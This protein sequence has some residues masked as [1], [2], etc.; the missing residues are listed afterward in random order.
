MTNIFSEGLKPPI[1]N[2]LCKKI[3][4]SAGLS[5]AICAVAHGLGAHGAG[6]D[7]NLGGH[8]G[9]W[10]GA[11]RKPWGKPRETIGKWWFNGI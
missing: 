10:R 11:D 6:F 3:E 4:R 8:G 9:E 1:G 5:S 7:A 2:S